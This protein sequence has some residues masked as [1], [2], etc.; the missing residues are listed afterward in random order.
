MGAGLPEL[1]PGYRAGLRS[2]PRLVN[3]GALDHDMPIAFGGP[4]DPLKGRRAAPGF[5]PMNPTA[6]RGGG[7]FARDA[8]EA[9]SSVERLT[10]PT[11]DDVGRL[12]GGQENSGPPQ[13]PGSRRQASSA[14]FAQLVEDAGSI[15]P[16]APSEEVDG[17]PQPTAN[18]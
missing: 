15:L 1:R 9:I 4:S 2:V 13:F 18:Q 17:F 5:V 7:S 11:E 16:S 6:P 8:S 10:G 12:G 3:P 14:G